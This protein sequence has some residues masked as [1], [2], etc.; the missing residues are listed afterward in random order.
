MRSR[1]EVL[2]DVEQRVAEACGVLNAAHAKLVALTAE[3]ISTEL[4]RGYGIRSVEHWLTLKAGLSPERARQVA[5]VAA[6]TAEMPVTA[7]TFSDGELSFEQVHAVAKHS[8]KFVDAEAASFARVATVPQIRRT[9]S[10]YT[11]DETAINDCSDGTSP[12][13]PA[14]ENSEPQSRTAEAAAAAG[15]LSMFHDGSRFSLHVDA[16]PDEGALIEAALDEAKQSLF[17]AGRPSVTWL[18]ALVEVC[19]RSLSAVEPTARADKYRIYVHLD[20]EGAWLNAGPALP[21]A[22]LAKLTCT[23]S[24]AP[25]WETAGKPVNV[26]RAQRIVPDR[27]RRLVEDRDR[28]C[29][30]PGCS[31]RSY[32]EVHHVT[33]WRDGGSTDTSNLACPCP[34]HHDAHH[35]GEFLIGGDADDSD[36]LRFTDNR[37]KLITIGRP[38]PP[39]DPL[40]RPP[41]GHHYTHPVGEPVQQKWVHFTPLASTA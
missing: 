21:P 24:I 38:H 27:T 32:L 39:D 34:H 4:W 13:D 41:V 11:F 6:A 23:G 35:R 29:R 33:H 9:L 3:L 5:E 26:G 15:R 31:A 22:L 14:G 40:P 25:V 20:T 30:Y 18:D 2:F 37:G 19:N 1:D 7:R 8:G 17:L 36:G 16:P 28:G 10:R 12:D